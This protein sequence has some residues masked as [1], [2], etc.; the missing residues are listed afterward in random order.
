MVP[1]WTVCVWL[2]FRRR[3]LTTCVRATSRRNSTRNSARN[4]PTSIW[5]WANCAAW[6]PTYA[7]SDTCMWVGPT[8]P[9]HPFWGRNSTRSFFEVTTLWRYTNLFIIISDPGTQ[10]VGNEKNYATQYKKVQKSSWNEPYSAFSGTA[11]NSRAVRWHCTADSKLI[12]ESTLNYYRPGAPRWYA[13]SIRGRVRS[14]HISDGRP[15]AGSQHAYSLG[16]CAVHQHA[17]A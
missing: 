2:W 12:C 1:L 8:Q 5:R 11:Q 6:R 15:A 16:S 4:S 13:P 9:G 7:R 10:F 17:I 3:W 14:L